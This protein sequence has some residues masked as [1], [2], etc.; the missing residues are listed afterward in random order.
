MER[1]EP[2]LVPEWLRCTGNIAGGGASVH[3]SDVSSSAHSTRNR[4]FRSNS[5]KESP[6]LLQRSSSSNS[7]RS[8]TSNGSAKHP[9]S[10]FSR[11]HWDR[12]RDREKEKSL[13]EDIWEHDSS[14]SFSSI[15]NSRVERSALRRSQSLVSRKNGEPSPRRVENKDLPV[16]GNGVLSRGSNLNV[17]QK[18]VFEKDFPSLGTEDKQGAAGI[19]RVS[20][21][22]LSSAVQSLPIGSSGFLGGEKWTSALA[23]V[24]ATVANNGTG[25]SPLQHNISTFPNLSSGVSTTAGLNMAEALSQPAVRV[26]ANPQLPD[27][28]QRLEELAIKQSR[29]LI[30]VTPPMPKPLVPGTADKSKQSKIALRTNEM[31]VAPKAVHP[32]AHPSHLAS[33]SRAGQIRSDSA[34][35][36]HV[37]KFLVLKPGRESIASGAK[38]VSSPT[39]NANGKVAKDGQLPMASG[40]VTAA[41]SSSN[42][43]VSAL[44]NKSAAL[45]LSSRSSADKRSSQSLAQ[46]R[47]EFF[48][49]MRRKTSVRTS[50]IHSNSSLDA[51]SNSSETSGENCKEGHASASPCVLDNGNQMVCNG[52]RYNMTKKTECLSDVGDSSLSCHGLINPDEEEAAFLR[53]LGWEENGGEDEGLTEEE[54]NAFY[55]YMNRRPSLEVCQSSQPKCPTASKFPNAVSDANSDSSSSESEPEA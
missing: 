28:S 34:S 36:P 54:I 22:G 8:S 47:S 31:T 48:N 19:R 26:H 49:L 16:S 14:D 38:D 23:E 40:P 30:P 20:S 25:H 41:M 4:S 44:E 17:M 11:S 53:S 45:S 1:T 32:Q 51:L 12:N 6:R 2:A 42:P 10:S 9:Y 18:S 43:M 3:L 46:S 7:R 52:D 35:N 50:A 39:G 24:P 29:Q 5:E 27:K 21:P 37:G 15:L 33:Q 13:S 55:Q